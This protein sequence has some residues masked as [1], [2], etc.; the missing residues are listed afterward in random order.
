MLRFHLSLNVSNLPKAVTFF[1]NILGVPAAKQRLDY[2]KFELD[3]PPLV[4][5]LEPRSPAQHGS[6]NHAGFRFADS[7]SLVDAQARLEKAGITTQREEG[8]ECCYSKQ[9]KFWVHDLDHRLWEFYTL[10]EDLDHRGDGQS[11]DD[12]VGEAAAAAIS[13]TPEPAIWEHRML[14]P[15]APPTSPCDQVRLRGTFN[16]PVSNEQ[17][18]SQLAQAFKTLR[19][20][21]QVTVHILTSEEPVG[22]ELH[23]PGPAAYVKYAP[24]R[25]E[26]MAAIE[27]AG[28][29]DQQLAT[30]RSGACFEHEGAPLRETQIIARRPEYASSE[31]C[32]VV[33]K[34]PFLSVLD[35]EGH[36]WHRGEAVSI[37]RSRWEALK[38]SSVAELFV[39]L[40]ESAAVSHCGV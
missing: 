6:L 38:A 31:T 5:S 21:G 29:V 26:L 4:L 25:T 40:P 11:L 17:M 1:Q 24:V 8:V 9:T 10:D 36:Q 20:G 30:F 3:S 39:M 13:D 7:Q 28:F 33:F 32:N 27:A 35:D 15:F 14:E 16:V 2:A 22:G 19:P 12:M 34:G 23:L 37:P 18:Q